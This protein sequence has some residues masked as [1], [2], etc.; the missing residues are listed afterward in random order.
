MRTESRI[1]PSAQLEIEA[2][3]KKEGQAC[4]AIFNVNITGPIEK[5]EGDQCYEYDRY[6]LDM[7]YREGLEESIQENFEEYLQ[8][9]IE[10]EHAE[11]PKTVEE[12]LKEH[13]DAIDEILIAILG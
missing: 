1:K 10:A 3:P 11:K 4:V 12:V 2:L 5:E 6:T 13:S 8:K 7:L 9:A